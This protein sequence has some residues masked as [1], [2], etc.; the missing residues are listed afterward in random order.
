M[1]TA[2]V[3]RFKKRLQAERQG[4]RKALRLLLKNIEIEIDGDFADRA[5]R[6]AERERAV[7]GITRL[8]CRLQLLDR[9]IAR[10]RDGAFGVCIRCGAEIPI[11]RLEIVPVSPY[12]VACQER[13]ELRGSALSGVGSRYLLVNVPHLSGKRLTL[14]REQDS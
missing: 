13:L 2:R 3:N 4:W 14:A 12:C 10:V 7:E 8:R 11:K 9:A 5:R 6:L 1:T